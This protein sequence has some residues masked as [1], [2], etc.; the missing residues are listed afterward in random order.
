MALK[1]RGGRRSSSGC[2]QCA[3]SAM[4]LLLVCEFEFGPRPRN[5]HGT[6][7]CC[8]VA[9]LAAW[10]CASTGCRV[11]ASGYAVLQLLQRA[12]ALVPVRQQEKLAICVLPTGRCVRQVAHAARGT[13][14]HLNGRNSREA[15]SRLQLCV[16]SHMH[17][18]PVASAAGCAA[19]RPTVGAAAGTGPGGFGEPG[20][21]SGASSSLEAVKLRATM[22]PRCRTAPRPRERA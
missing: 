13:S 7:G 16:G 21:P 4:C 12:H 20:L 9:S 3:T 8:L 1:R 10:M 5:H 14:E 19:W 6:A 2:C 18:A 22:M 17:A 11:A 15:P